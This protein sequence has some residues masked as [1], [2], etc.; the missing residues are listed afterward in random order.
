[1]KQYISTVIFKEGIKCN[2]HKFG[3]E[4]LASYYD[5]LTYSIG[6]LNQCV[7][8]MTHLL[9]LIE[10]LHKLGKDIWHPKRIET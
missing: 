1:M 10:S 3:T 5:S 6:C 2:K 8:K 9:T 7:A 4:N